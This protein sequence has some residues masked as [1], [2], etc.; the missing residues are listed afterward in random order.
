MS[1]PSGAPRVEGAH[2][3][4]DIQY[5]ALSS[6]IAAIQGRF[7]MGA[8]D[9]FIYC[10]TWQAF[11]ESFG[12]EPLSG[13]EMDY[14]FVW[15]FF[16]ASVGKGALWVKNVSHYTDY[17][18]PGTATA[19]KATAADLAA[20]RLRLSAY[21]RGEWAHA[22]NDN[23][24]VVIQAAASGM[25][26]RYDLLVYLDGVV[27]KQYLSG[28]W[29][30][31]DT[32]N[33][34]DMIPSAGD[35]YIIPTWDG[36][37]EAP[38]TGTYQFTGGN[39][40]LS[41]LVA[42][43]WLGA[44]HA[45]GNTGWRALLPLLTTIEQR[46]MAILDQLANETYGESI[47]SG[48]LTFCE[49]NQ[50][51]FYSATPSGLNRTTAANYI[52]GDGA[53]SVN[54]RTQYGTG[55]VIFPWGYPRGSTDETLL[56]PASAADAGRAAFVAATYGNESP[57]EPHAGTDRGKGFLGDVFRS[58]ERDTNAADS[59]A[60]D[61]IRVVVIRTDIRRSPYIYGSWSTSYDSRF[62]AWSVRLLDTELMAG[63]IIQSE[64]YVHGLNDEG[65]ENSPGVRRR[66]KNSLIGFMKIYS[67]RGA[68]R[69]KAYGTGYQVEDLTTDTDVENKIVRM[70]MS[71]W[72]R[73]VVK[74]IY[75]T[76]N[77]TGSAVTV[78]AE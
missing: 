41:G 9:E 77:P 8:H 59:S 74:V 36:S 49:A 64:P 45:D 73:N 19:A 15:S 3:T 51:S 58:M 2:S 27:V 42:N 62:D 70:K 7:K 48:L 30:S 34:R 69:S 29:T 31:T 38:A 1:I 35:G 76:V 40:G 4:A 10:P 60:L 71:Y 14:W 66:L 56:I 67:E 12:S 37:S 21:S 17:Q 23:L 54:K 6:G 13:Y 75:L 46:P 52:K 65:Y 20:K 53:Y 24:Q 44:E 28:S 63:A 68:F 16:T 11:K 25:A 32:N 50:L 72:Y 55:R 26:S 78:T 22:A 18:N 39:D 61:D 33:F 5:S 43:D 47:Y 57:H